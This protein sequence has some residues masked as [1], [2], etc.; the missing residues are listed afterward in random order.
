[1]WPR[2]ARQCS[3]D[4]EYYFT[5]SI[6]EQTAAQKATCNVARERHDELAAMYRFRAA[7]LSSHP[8]CW[9]EPASDELVETA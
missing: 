4:A 6:Q 9:S 5:R 7:M 2:P 8:P 1:M 3:D